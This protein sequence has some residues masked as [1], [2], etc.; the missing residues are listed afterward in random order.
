MY[1]YKNGRKSCLFL[2]F[3]VKRG[4][5]LLYNRKSLM[6]FVFK[7]KDGFFRKTNEQ[8]DEG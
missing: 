6:K 2:F 1:K 5:I 8:T 7:Y 4:R 3:Y